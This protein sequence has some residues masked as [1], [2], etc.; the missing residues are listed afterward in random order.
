MNPGGNGG[1]GG[2]DSSVKISS[3]FIHFYPLKRPDFF[4]VW[5]G[6]PPPGSFL[7]S[8][9]APKWAAWTLTSVLNIVSQHHIYTFHIKIPPQHVSVQRRRCRHARRNFLQPGLCIACACNIL[10]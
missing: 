7:L 9:E 5:H 4:S 6:P 8:I 10:G 3:N 1:P 2:Q